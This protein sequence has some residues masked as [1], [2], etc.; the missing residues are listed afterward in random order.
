MYRVEFQARLAPHVHGCA[1]MK[2]EKLEKCRIK[3]TCD[4]DPNSRDLKELKDEYV[5]CELQED[6]DFR[7]TVKELQT[8]KCSKT[9]KKKGP[10]C[11]FGFPRLPSNN[12][13]ISI[14][15]NKDNEEEKEELK[16]AKE[17]VQKMRSYLESE[18]FDQDL[19]LEEI[20]EKLKVQPDAY[21]RAL[22]ISE[23]GSK[24]F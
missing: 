9:C 17:I 14:P 18:E 6:E 7:K 16:K 19:K 20:L 4:F 12:T 24:L 1:W 22:L 5:I 11:R 3:G 13:L 15:I 2:D 23:R 8:H 10:H 21:E